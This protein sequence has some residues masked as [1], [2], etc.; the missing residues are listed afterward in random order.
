MEHSRRVFADEELWESMEGDCQVNGRDMEPPPVIRDDPSAIACADD[1]MERPLLRS[2]P[3]YNEEPPPPDYHEASS[4]TDNRAR[5]GQQRTEEAEA[6]RVPRPTTPD[7]EAQRKPG[8][9]SGRRI[10]FHGRHCKICGDGL[11]YRLAYRN[12]P[13]GCYSVCASMSCKPAYYGSSVPFAYK[14]WR[15]KRYCQCGWRIRFYTVEEVNSIYSCCQMC[16]NW[17]EYCSC[18]W[19]GED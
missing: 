1:D 17:V 4:Q 15:Q 5:E 9:G 2:P 13:C 12:G 18:G 16:K 6:S 11:T 14:F 7:F 3:G 19:C 10:L 8:P